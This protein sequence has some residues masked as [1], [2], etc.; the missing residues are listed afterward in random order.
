MDIQRHLD[1]EPVVARPPSAAYRFQKLVRRNKVA[2]AASSAV[3]AALVLGLGLSTWLFIRERAAR[4]QAVGARKEAERA[5]QNEAKLRQRAEHQ[6]QKAKTE[7]GK[8][9]QVAE[10]LK[11]MLA[12]VGPWV[13]LGRDTTMLREIWIRPPSESVKT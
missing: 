11:D 10:F 4:Q 3:L 9:Q 7:A 5:R 8:S 6:E 13:A 1:N 12:G 2:F